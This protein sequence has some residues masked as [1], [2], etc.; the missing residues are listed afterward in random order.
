ML[1]VDEAPLAVM[2]QRD[3]RPDSTLTRL[4]GSSGNVNASIGCF[5]FN[6]NRPKIK[7]INTLTSYF[8][9]SHYFNFVL[10][11]PFPPYNQSSKFNSETPI[12][13]CSVIWQSKAAKRVY[14]LKYK[15]C[16][17][18]IKEI[19]VVDNELENVNQVRNRVPPWPEYIFWWSISKLAYGNLRKVIVVVVPTLRYQGPPW[20]KFHF[21]VDMF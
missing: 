16:S 3:W 21:L 7:F 12:L 15:L 2:T 9:V 19:W 13:C 10:P 5:R 8:I 1:W 20:P 17:T 6:S 4:R 11:L 14:H 18:T